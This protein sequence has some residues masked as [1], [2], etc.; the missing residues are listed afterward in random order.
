MGIC[1][2]FYFFRWRH[3]KDRALRRNLGRHGVPNLLVKIDRTDGTVVG[4]KV[5]T[6]A[7]N[8]QC[9]IKYERVVETGPLHVATPDE[10]DPGS[11]LVGNLIILNAMERECDF[12][13][14]LM[15]AWCFHDHHCC[16]YLFHYDAISSSNY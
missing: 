6:N 13:K 10:N 7:S 14:M 12:V 11:A 16:V 2:R 3:L 8:V 1:P 5:A 15:N 4:T 9:L